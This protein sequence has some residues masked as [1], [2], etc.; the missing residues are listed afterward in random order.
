MSLFASFEIGWLAYVGIFLGVLLAFDGLYQLLSRSET[1]GE[2]RNRRMRMIAAGASAEDVLRLLKPAEQGR[3]FT[4][5]PFVGSLPA[6][7]RRA[8]L[9]I[10]PGLFL[11]LCVGAALVMALAGSTMFPPVLA[12]V[13]A[14]AVCVLLP[15]LIVRTKSKSRLD[16]LVRQLPEALDLMAR[17]LIVGHP[18]NTTI[19]AVAND[20]LD[21][22]ASEFGVMVDQVAYGDDLSNAFAEFATRTGLEDAHYLAVA[23]AIQ[24]G[25]G[26]NLANVLATL[27]KVIRDR[28]T[29]RKKIK[30]VSA[31]GRLTAYFLSALPLAVFGVTSFM[32]PTYYGDVVDDPLF[33]PF[34]ITVIALVVANFLAMRKLVNFRF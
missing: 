24:H 18:L 13:T 5:L 8:G 32:T 1:L 33:R 34:A 21:P 11:A 9:T 22:V 30:A 31:E 7:L 26:G 25:T 16:K 27:S 19:S 12:V 4:L 14:F 15:A 23:V 28:I 20:M 2:A 29:M 6:D 10:A 3:G 17:G